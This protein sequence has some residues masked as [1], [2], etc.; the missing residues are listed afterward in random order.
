MRP[1]AQVGHVF[2]KDVKEHRWFALL[3][4]VSIVVATGHALD[5][6]GLRGPGLGAAMVVVGI[7]GILLVASVMQGDSPTRSDAFWVSHPFDPFA[8]LSAKV[9][10]ALLVLAIAVIGQLIVV[11][12]YDP[13][14]AALRKVV[15]DPALVFGWLIVTALALAALTRDLRSFTL[16]AIGIPVVLGLT[17]GFIVAYVTDMVRISGTAFTVV[18]WGS[19]AIEV[20]L[21]VWLYRTRDGRWRTRILGFVAA[22]LA[23]VTIVS[24]GSDDG[25]RTAASVPRV[26]ITVELPLTNGAPDPGSLALTLVVPRAPEGLIYDVNG[27]VAELRDRDGSI[28]YVPLR[29]GFAEFTTNLRVTTAHIPDVRWLGASPPRPMRVALSGPLSAAQRAAIDAG[30]TTVAVRASVD[31]DTLRAGEP[32]RLAPGNVATRGGR[33]TIIEEWTRVPGAVKLGVRSAALVPDP[34][35]SGIGGSFTGAEYALIN[36]RR[37]E[38]LALARTETGMSIAGLVL[39]GSTITSE[40]VRYDARVGMS[41]ADSLPDEA[42]F[43]DAELIPVTRVP[44]GSYPITL[45]VPRP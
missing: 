10:F 26:P 28:S 9:V 19:R 29:W 38:A 12:S 30:R 18:K 11:D 20:G 33:R 39:P 45:R 36:R 13:D 35:L 42:W 14:R 34:P 5:W 17:A 24:S 32:I 44:L 4:L 27:L 21:L 37:G 22:G 16:A 40:K 25:T 31:V 1:L 7:V 15:V 41:Q 43:R 8:V 3:Y 2:V 6:R 23:I